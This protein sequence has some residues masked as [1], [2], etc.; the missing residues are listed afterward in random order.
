MSLKNV[1]ISGLGGGIGNA[2]ASNN[3]NVPTFHIKVEDSSLSDLSREAIFYRTDPSKTIGTVG[4][5]Y[6]RS[7]RR[8]ARQHAA[9][10]GSSTTAWC[11]W[12]VRSTP[13]SSRLT[14]RCTT[15]RNCHRRATIAKRINVFGSNNYWGGGPPTVAT[16]PFNVASGKN[17]VTSGKVTFTS[18]SFLATDPD[19]P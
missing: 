12:A 11:R 16:G 19:A 14:S 2:G 4:G 13:S 18:T 8:A 1:S 10:T 9:A 3:N 5:A 15:Q 6:R 17:V 7:R